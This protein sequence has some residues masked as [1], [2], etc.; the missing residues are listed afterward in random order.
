MQTGIVQDMDSFSA[1]SKRFIHEHYTMIAGI[2]PFV[3][4]ERERTKVIKKI[5]EEKNV[6]QRT[7]RNY[8]CLYLVYQD[9]SVLAP[10]QKSGSRALTQDEKNIRWALN[11][12][13]YNKH[14][15]SLTTA[16]TMM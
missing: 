2:L 13:F 3:S 16:Y 14:K 5:A 9:I 15:N 1:E 11:K 6:S 7:I 10:K 8:L 12:F 4:E